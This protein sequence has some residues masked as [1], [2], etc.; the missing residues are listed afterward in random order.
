[1]RAR[2]RRPRAPVPELRRA[3]GQLETFMRASNRWRHARVS[4][5]MRKV[6]AIAPRARC[7]SSQAAAG[8]RG[9]SSSRGPGSR[10]A[11]HGDRR[12]AAP[13][14]ASLRRCRRA[15][16]PAVPPTPPSRVRHPAARRRR[17]D[18][19]RRGDGARLRAR[20]PRQ[21]QR[22]AAAGLR[23]AAAARR[24]AD[25]GCVVV[26]ARRLSGVDQRTQGQGGWTAGGQDAGQ[27]RR[28]QR[29]RV[30]DRRRR[31]G[32]QPLLLVDSHR[33]PRGARDR[34]HAF[35]RAENY[36]K[37]APMPK[38]K[39]EDGRGS[40]SSALSPMWRTCQRR[41][42]SPTAHASSPACGSPTSLH[43]DR[44]REALRGAVEAVG[45]RRGETRGTHSGRIRRQAPDR[46]RWH[47]GRHRAAP[48][49]GT[50]R[51]GPRRSWCSPGCNETC[52]RSSSR[53][54]RR[55]APTV[56]RMDVDPDLARRARRAR[57]SRRHGH[58]RAA[59]WRRR[60]RR[61][62]GHRR[63]RVAPSIPRIA[64]TTGQHD[65]RHPPHRR[66]A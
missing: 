29:G 64:R 8:S 25:R 40:G 27:A 16:V 55:H 49:S 7:G 20:R 6:F 15:G 43:R 56:D 57:R 33:A 11:R 21:P 50:P 38:T 41:S 59:A 19:D 3:A 32:V 52:R 35:C 9:S 46:S 39:H 53:A 36:W 66:R 12:P 62:G 37:D 18:P 44:T 13:E 42:P 58:R 63:P 60:A 47:R 28:P 34:R 23:G 2:E 22:T 48:T 54:R 30:P 17:R 14:R 45:A 51:S 61:W 26:S 65:E 1:M 31:Q 4:T 24:E 10:R 5:F